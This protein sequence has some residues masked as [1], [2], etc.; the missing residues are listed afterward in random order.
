MSAEISKKAIEN[1]LKLQYSENKQLKT[2]IGKFQH[3]I[4]G[5]V[6]YLESSEN[7][8]EEL[9]NFHN[10]H[11]E[12]LVRDSTDL[13]VLLSLKRYLKPSNEIAYLDLHVLLSTIL[14]Q[15]GLE[16]KV[17]GSPQNAPVKKAKITNNADIGVLEAQQ[18]DL[19]QLKKAIDT[20]IEQFRNELKHPV[21]LPVCVKFLENKIATL[22][23]KLYESTKSLEVFKEDNFKMHEKISM[24][25]TLR[26]ILMPS[27]R[28]DKNTTS[29]MLSRDEILLK[30]L[31]SYEKMLNTEKEN[32]RVLLDKIEELC[33]EV[34]M[35]KLFKY[36][37]RQGESIDGTQKTKEQTSENVPKLWGYGKWSESIISAMEEFVNGVV[38]REA[39]STPHNA[40]DMQEELNLYKQ[41]IRC[42]VCNENKKDSILAKCSHTFCKGCLKSNL[43]VR[44]RKCP[45]CK[46]VYDNND[47]R[48]FYL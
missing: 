21:N 12:S 9:E 33:E 42:S 34:G 38:A 5:I 1:I 10:E 31:E 6:L 13:N 24:T 37:H 18:N 46:T 41:A 45:T 44:N 29:N 19:A 32:N 40:Q 23:Q 28:Q 15:G 20:A 11:I 47:I 35:L 48:V 39:S 16:P 36:R 7:N 8:S 43:R 3:L 14:D 25:D 26:S 4:K 30:E 27:S 2:Q 17:S 22:T